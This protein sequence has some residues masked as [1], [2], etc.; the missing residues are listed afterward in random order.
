[1]K[2]PRIPKL[3]VTA[4]PGR[5][6]DAVTDKNPVYRKKTPATHRRGNLIFELIDSRPHFDL[7]SIYSVPAE[8]SKS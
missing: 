6:G 1:M 5:K 4:S 7:W 2:T 8:E 3:S